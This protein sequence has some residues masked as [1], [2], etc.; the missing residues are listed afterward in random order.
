MTVD[1]AAVA[2]YLRVDEAALVDP[3]GVVASIRFHA[4]QRYTEPTSDDQAPEFDADARATWERALVMAA[5]ALCRRQNTT[6]KTEG[7][8]GTGNRPASSAAVALADP[9]VA[10]LLAPFLNVAVFGAGGDS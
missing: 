1:A 4:A 3:E 8:G 6:G 7:A 9:T 5:A 10:Q 2:A